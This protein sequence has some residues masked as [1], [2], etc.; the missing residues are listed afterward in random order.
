[1]RHKRPDKNNPH[2]QPG[3]NFS[4]TPSELVRWRC[5]NCG[6]QFFCLPE[7][8]PPDICDYCQDMTTW[9]QLS[10]PD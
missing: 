2:Q 6:Q 3:F 5:M 8:E 4:D 1:M 10:P 9:Q 7:E